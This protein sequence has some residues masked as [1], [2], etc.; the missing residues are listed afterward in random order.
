MATS[1]RPEGGLRRIRQLHVATPAGRSGILVKDSRHV[2]SYRTEPISADDQRVAIALSMPVRAQSYSTTPMLP[3]FQ[4]SLPEGFLRDR[5]ENKFSKVVRMDDMALLAL[6]GA[7]RI[8]R[9]RISE[10]DEGAPESPGA[11]SLTQILEHE[12]TLNLF[13]ELC[14]KYLISSGIAG[15]QP[16]VVLAAMDDTSSSIRDV[17][18]DSGESGHAKASIGEK[19]TLRGKGLVIKVNADDYPGLTENEFHCLQIASLCGITVPKRW[20]SKDGKRLAIERFD[21]DHSTGVPLAFEDMVSVMGTVNDRKYEGSYEN[22]AKAISV[23]ASE[24]FIASSMREL[25]QAVVLSVVLGN[26]DGH[27]KNF[28]LLYTDP[29]TPDCRLSPLYD[30]VCTTVYLRNDRLALSLDKSRK[31]PSREALLDFGRKHCRLSHPQYVIDEIVEVAAQY[32]ATE[33][34][35]HIWTK[36]KPLIDDACSRLRD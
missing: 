23:N 18:S 31:W 6:S 5:I 1:L 14:D 20:L 32:R 28:G 24:A 22:L 10:S 34:Y 16:K 17:N 33:L 25:F 29:T 9:L 2:F 35:S 4:T 30:I 15:A 8:G 36:M 3:V 7:N 27:L 13:Q 26:G 21:I 12:G 19:S 11:E